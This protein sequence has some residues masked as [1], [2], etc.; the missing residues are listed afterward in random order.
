MDS[1][2]ALALVAL[3]QAY[4]PVPELPQST[5]TVWANALTPYDYEPAQ[6][7]VHRLGRGRVARGPLQLAEVLDV[8]DEVRQESYERVYQMSEARARELMSELVAMAP[9]EI[10]RHLAPYP[11]R[12]GGG[13][14]GRPLGR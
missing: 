12:F 10:R 13:A 14:G 5:Q 8:C 4:F 7:A 6:T 2:Q 9:E 1:A 3:L 11:E